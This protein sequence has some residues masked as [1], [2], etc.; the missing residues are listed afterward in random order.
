MMTRDLEISPKFAYFLNKQGM[1]DAL[2]IA[3][4]SFREQQ[5]FP[6]AI[7]E[8][9]IA[10]QAVFKGLCE[11]YASRGFDEKELITSKE[12]LK[13]VDEV[14]SSIWN[15]KESLWNK[16]EKTESGKMVEETIIKQKE[17][18]EEVNKNK[19]TYTIDIKG[20]EDIPDFH[21][22]CLADSKEE[23]YEILIKENPGLK[24][25]TKSAVAKIIK[26]KK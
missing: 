23:A 12:I 22:E 4:Q 20:G 11:L 3:Y 9:R 6:F 17:K 18:I 8:K 10:K 25:S 13:E 14:V 2:V 7:K 16:R 21:A 26:I 24:K 15:E 19:K 5:N 1:L